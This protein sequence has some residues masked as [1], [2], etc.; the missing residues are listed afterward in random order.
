[1]FVNNILLLVIKI[2]F[3]LSPNVIWYHFGRQNIKAVWGRKNCSQCYVFALIRVKRVTEL[4][5][6]RVVN[7]L[8]IYL[9]LLCLADGGELIVR[10]CLLK[11]KGCELIIHDLEPDLMWPWGGWMYSIRLAADICSLN[12]TVNGLYLDWYRY[13]LHI[14][15]SLSQKTEKLHFP[16]QSLKYVY[17]DY[18]HHKV[19]YFPCLHILQYRRNLSEH[20]TICLGASNAFT[21]ELCGGC[22][23][24]FCANWLHSCHFDELHSS[25]F[26][27]NFASYRC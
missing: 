13:M 20:V 26:K 11:K 10:F 8:T 17:V 2:L 5:G 12:L 25:Y 6:V 9:C 16:G 15:N 27:W 7:K 1:M 22:C 19:N 21:G 14:G 24:H 3:N 4:N 18:L 23:G